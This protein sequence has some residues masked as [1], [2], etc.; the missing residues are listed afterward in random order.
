MIK[1]IDRLGFG[2]TR[3]VT[4]DG[5]GG[6]IV[7]VTPPKLLGPK[8][9]VTVQLTPDQYARYLQWEDGMLMQNALWDLDAATREML[10][11]GL[12]NDDFHKATRSDEE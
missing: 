10:M 5:E 12:T 1:P 4:E 2:P 9:T 8:P 3:V 11:T 7:M 6:Y